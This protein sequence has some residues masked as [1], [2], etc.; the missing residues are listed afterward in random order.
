MR[1]RLR[2][3]RMGQNARYVAARFCNRVRACGGKA[4][5]YK[6]LGASHGAGCWTSESMALIRR[7]LKATV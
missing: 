4:E 6:I 3:C 7:F 5:F 2:S 1:P